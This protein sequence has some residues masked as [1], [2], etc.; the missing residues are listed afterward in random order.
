[1]GRDVSNSSKALRAVSRA[2][3]LALLALSVVELADA[4]PRRRGAGD[5]MVVIPAGSI[6]PF[7]G[8]E[9]RAPVPVASF[10]IDVEPVTHRAFLGFV[11]EHPR[12]RRGA[13]TRLFA[14]DRYL[15]D[16]S[17]ELELGPSVRAE[18]P[19]VFVSWFAARAFCAAR[20]ARLPTET[21]WEYVAR[22]DASR[23]DASRDPAFVRQILAWYARPAATIGD[24]GRSG[25]NLFGVR[26]LHGLVWEWVE[27]FNASMVSADDR[28]RDDDQASRVCGG[29]ASGASDPADYAA[30][31]RFA[32][33]SSLSASY[34]VHNLGFRCARSIERTP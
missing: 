10:A 29:A 32:F 2:G 27:D 16:W 11:R 20:G 31:M 15:R 30:F 9:D 33:R 6:V 26:D 12:W 8:A 4:Q 22:A 21:E 24:V 25:P 28:A 18:S 7:Y 19:V 5:G 13:V 1:M 17:A 3:A 34:T 14:D 23:P